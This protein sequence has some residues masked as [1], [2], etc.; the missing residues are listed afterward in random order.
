MCKRVDGGNAKD[1]SQINHLEIE[2]RGSQE[3]RTRN[4]VLVGVSEGEDFGKERRMSCRSKPFSAMG[5]LIVTLEEQIHGV[6]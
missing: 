6:G 3:R 4:H 2:V 1:L 5:H